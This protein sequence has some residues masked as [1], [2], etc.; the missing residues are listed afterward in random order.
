MGGGGAGPAPE[1]SEGKAPPQPLPP[2]ARSHKMNFRRGIFYRRHRD[3]LKSILY[4]IL[5]HRPEVFASKMRLEAV[6]QG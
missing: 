4:L 5:H 2:G 1:R 3:R 6:L